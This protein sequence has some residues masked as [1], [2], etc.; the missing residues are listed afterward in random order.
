M[1]SSVH[2]GA[3]VTFV[4]LFIENAPEP[5]G[6][7]RR[8]QY[9]VAAS[10]KIVEDGV[11]VS[12]WV[13]GEE[14]AIT[15]EMTVPPDP[16]G[17]DEPVLITACI[18]LLLLLTFT[19]ISSISKYDALDPVTKLNVLCRL[20]GGAKIPLP[21]GPVTLEAKLLPPGVKLSMTTTALT[22]DVMAIAAISDGRVYFMGVG[23]G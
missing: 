3:V 13:I 4:V 1:F 21:T 17:R 23:S 15:V 8:T 5:L 16:P 18:P 22:L 20:G 19:T 9:W 11:N 7:L 6:T 14:A 2:P 10:S 12:T